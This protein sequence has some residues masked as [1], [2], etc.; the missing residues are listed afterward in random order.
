MEGRTSP[1]SQENQRAYPPQEAI[2]IMGVRKSV[3]ADLPHQVRLFL[4]ES[5][6]NLIDR[7]KCYHSHQ[8]TKHN[9]KCSQQVFA[10]V[11]GS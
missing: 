5:F 3:L 7:A 10:I 11:N 8:I 4:Q 9:P 2:P 1:S 6:L